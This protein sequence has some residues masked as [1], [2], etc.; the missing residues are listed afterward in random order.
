MQSQG[1]K[2]GIFFDPITMEP[3]LNTPAAREALILYKELVMSSNHV[4]QGPKGAGLGT[5]VQDMQNGKCMMGFNYMGPIKFI[6]GGAFNKAN[7][8]IALAPVPGSTRVRSSDGNTL[9]DCNEKES[10]CPY[11]TVEP[12]NVQ[13]KS[14]TSGETHRVNRATYY[15]GGGQSWAISNHIRNPAKR[16]AL[17]E[18]F[19]GVINPENAII[20]TALP[21]FLLDPFRQSTLDGMQVA[22]HMATEHFMKN[23][24]KWE[25]LGTMKSTLQTVFTDK[26]S[27]FDLKFLDGD[28]YIEEA[29]APMLKYFNGE[30]SVDEAIQKIT[31]KWNVRTNTLGKSVQRNLYRGVL[32]LQPYYEELNCSA[33][34]EAMQGRCQPCDV[35]KFKAKDGPELCARCPV[36]KFQNASGARQ[37]TS[38]EDVLKS[39]STNGEGYTSGQ[40]CACPGNTFMFQS[41]SD[42]RCKA[43]PDGMNCAGGRAPPLLKEGFYVSKDEPYSVWRCM[44]E[45]VCPGQTDIES[46]VCLQ[47][48]HG[49][50]CGLCEAGHYTCDFECCE[51]NAELLVIVPVLVA[52]WLGLGL[53]HHLWNRKAAHVEA[54]ENVLASVTI[55]TSLTFVQGLSIISNLDF[56]W[57]EPFKSIRDICSL[58]LLNVD[59]L[60]PGCVVSES[61]ASKYG[62]KLLVLPLTILAFGLWLPA[63]YGL[64]KL[65]SHKFPKFDI[66]ELLSSIGAIYQGV[67]IGIAVAVL[68]LVDCYGSPN[69]K[70]TVRSMP[71]LECGSSE[72]YAALPFMLVSLLLFVV[73]YLAVTGWL[74]LVMP[75]TPKNH[76][77]RVAAK[78]LLF[79]FRPSAWYFAFPMAV[80]S[81]LLALVT[82]VAP[83][84]GHLQFLL[85]LFILVWALTVH[86]VNLPYQDRFGNYLETNELAFLLVILS[87][88]SWF[89]EDKQD[90]QKAK[91]LSWLLLIILMLCFVMVALIF[92]WG[93]YLACF[94]DRALKG[95]RKTVKNMSH[96]F[97]A[98]CRLFSTTSEDE[99]QTMLMS[100]SYVDRWHL[101]QVVD[102]V[103]V[104]VCQLMSTSFKKRRLNVVSNEVIMGSDNDISQHLRRR[105]SKVMETYAVSGKSTSLGRSSAIMAHLLAGPNTKDEA[106]LAQTSSTH[107]SVEEGAKTSSPESSLDLESI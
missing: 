102:F 60:S 84:D 8:T 50:N 61:I 91:V 1:P 16:E 95:T 88:G 73:G 83:D 31:E 68:G 21:H 25:Q 33:G 53:F 39:S 58:F 23:N 70:I 54:V 13:G 81:L 107:A 15:S 18:F 78:F 77:R 52:L 82:I 100:L 57:I 97:I 10:N 105:G 29:D 94:E 36:G 43:C 2:Q 80:R 44:P 30:L 4:E 64:H 96:D 104:E 63:S 19:R 37:C 92:S 75:G 62:T 86:L 85:M 9:V 106:Y 32:G 48:R 41:G 59:L 72:F 51:C 20:S 69:N 56:H 5:M 47:G 99:L 6:A 87:I 49:I 67:F 26:N 40:D 42:T 103:N 101:T 55:G 45:A 35:G 24:W 27:V 66:W 38:C 74:L 90:K 17:F 65:T 14:P 12:K 3:L 22:G 28:I 7:N 11:A 46:P 34:K 89:I 93:L 79:K 71:F 98:V 76:P